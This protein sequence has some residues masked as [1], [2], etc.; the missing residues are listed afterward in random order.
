MKPQPK[1]WLVVLVC[2]ALAAGFASTTRAGDSDPLPD[3]KLRCFINALDACPEFAATWKD[4]EA[5]VKDCGIPDDIDLATWKRLLEISAKSGLKSRVALQTHA[6]CQNKAYFDVMVSILGYESDAF[7]RCRVFAFM[8]EHFRDDPR[9]PSYG[10]L[11]LLDLWNAEWHDGIDARGNSPRD[12]VAL[13]FMQI[14]EDSLSLEI[15][16]EQC[17]T[18]LSKSKTWTYDKSEEIWSAK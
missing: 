3:A 9:T 16:A 2:C 13:E 6:V 15:T 1:F 17:G 11:L 8:S 7:T 4:V 10:L 14:W 12:V 5:C 18:L